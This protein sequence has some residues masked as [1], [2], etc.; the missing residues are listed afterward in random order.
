MRLRK[1]AEQ[2]LELPPQ[3]FERPLQAGAAGP[4]SGLP[5]SA[6]ALFLKMQST[7]APLQR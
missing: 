4:P 7:P 2:F 3:V 5:V 1:F 6:V